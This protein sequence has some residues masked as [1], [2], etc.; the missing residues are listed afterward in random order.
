MLPY[1]KLIH[2][3]FIDTAPDGSVAWII[4]AVI[5]GFARM[6]HWWQNKKEKVIQKGSEPGY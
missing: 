4:L 3:E 2:M 5:I 6:A 1:R